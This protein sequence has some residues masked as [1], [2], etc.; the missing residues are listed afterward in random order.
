MQVVHYSR[1]SSN[2]R[3]IKCK[4][5]S[6]SSI[7]VLSVNLNVYT[8]IIS[9]LN[10]QWRYHLLFRTGQQPG[11]RRKFHENHENSPKV[12]RFWRFDMGGGLKTGVVHNHINALLNY[13]S[14]IFLDAES[15]CVTY[16]GY[17][18]RYMLHSLCNTNFCNIP[19]SLKWSSD[20]SAESTDVGRHLILLI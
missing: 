9:W 8:L 12:R 10:T 11:S 3:L 1:I 4:Q 17:N 7:K 19:P 14:C 16:C 13:L 2:K 5:W 18:S 20:A 15:T 6:L